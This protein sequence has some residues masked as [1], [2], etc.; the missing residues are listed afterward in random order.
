MVPTILASP[1]HVGSGHVTLSCLGE[2]SRVYPEQPSYGRE[3]PDC[4]A[5]RP[6]GRFP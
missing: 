1:A 3:D 5:L 4:H 6:P 2:L